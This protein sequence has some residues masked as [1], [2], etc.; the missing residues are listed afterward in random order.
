MKYDILIPKN[1]HDTIYC[2]MKYHDIP[3][4]LKYYPALGLTVVP[5]TTFCIIK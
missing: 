2:P 3:K 5:S 4:I 1:I